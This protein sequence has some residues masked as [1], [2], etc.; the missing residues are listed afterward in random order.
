MREMR[1]RLIESLIGRPYRP[2]ADGPEAFDCYG[3]VRHVRM[4]CLDDALP[5]IVRP[6]DEAPCRQAIAR[7]LLKHPTKEQWKM[8]EVA[9]EW[10]VVLM[11]NVDQRPF[12]M[13]ICVRVKG[14]FAVLHAEAAPVNRVILDDLPALSLKGFNRLEFYRRV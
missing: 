5:L 2:G 10:D 13:G 12:H 8:H 9:E 11:G 3:V 4:H 7:T 6:V 14:Q 1:E